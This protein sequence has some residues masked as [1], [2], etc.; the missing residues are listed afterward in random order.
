ML[1]KCLLLLGM[2]LLAASAAHA[3]LTI[4][5]KSTN[6]A[7]KIALTNDRIHLAG[8]YAE[9]NFYYNLTEDLTPGDYFVQLA[10]EHSS[11]LIA[12]SALTVF[13][14]GK[15]IESF[16]LQEPLQKVKVM[17][18][19][20]ALT[21]GSHTLT[22]NFTGY[23]KEGICVPQDASANW[24]T[25]QV[26]SYLQL[27]NAVTTQPS[28]TDYPQR[29]MQDTLLIMPENPSV[30]TLEAALSIAQTLASDSVQ[31]VEEQDVKHV[32]EA[33]L[34]IGTAS[35]FS[36][37]WVKAL[38]ANE[39]IPNKGL[40][41]TTKHVQ[42]A[43]ASAQ[44]LLVTAQAAE[45][46]LLYP[47]LTTT[48]FMKQLASHTMTI[49]ALPAIETTP[50]LET[51][52]LKDIGLPS[53]TLNSQMTSTNTYFYYLPMSKHSLNAPS[54]TVNFKVSQLI[55]QQS[56][57][58][59]PN[60]AELIV[61]LNDVPHPIDLSEASGEQMLS[62][63]IPFDPAILKESQLLTVRIAG[64]GLAMKD[65][66]I[67]TDRTNWIYIDESSA[68]H[69]PIVNEVD[70]KPLAF[71]QFP[72]PF[73]TQDEKLTIVFADDVTTSELVGLYKALAIPNQQLDLQLLNEAT[74]EQLV[75]SHVIF[76]GGATKHPVLAGTDS[77]LVSYENGVPNL[78]EEGFIPTDHTTFAFLQPS[79]WDDNYAM[80]VLDRLA[81]T[82]PYI[83][84][85]TLN[86]LRNN[87][88]TA[89]ILTHQQEIVTNEDSTETENPAQQDTRWVYIWIACL[90]GFALIILAILYV[91][92]K[93]K[94]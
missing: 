71:Q 22:V 86:F 36:S 12:S 75:G 77:L 37:S 24:L 27:T 69:L 1:K 72:F 39:T 3:E 32:T 59:L 61:Y 48:H 20:E 21:E 54:F 28:L 83:A 90:L 40:H 60:N 18:P 73:V 13:I 43:E 10:L 88:S 63:T 49:P 16:S 80:L 34:L 42:H 74:P 2:L 33:F 55:S 82:S 46:M 15:P 7:N 92:K 67:T 78:L 35:E 66:C 44:M 26:T 51:I 23:M 29:F 31:L 64:N 57:E 89:T 30:E 93:R 84:E 38:L 70:N 50:L 76:V 41:L 94:R 85:E 8:P 62:E 5:I 17:L 6:A 4:P 53:F 45:D 56:T 47:M 58:L 52:Q 91:V 87:R 65:P 81:D 14:D 9:T 68:I 19:G 11:L 25:I 79:R